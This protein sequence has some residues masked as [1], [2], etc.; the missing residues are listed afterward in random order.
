MDDYFTIEKRVEDNRARMRE[1]YS[2]YKGIDNY[3]PFFL[4]YF[5]VL[6]IYYYDLIS[7]MFMEND[8]SWFTCLIFS[9]TFLIGYVSM[10]I[11]D[12]LKLKKDKIIIITDHYYRNVLDVTSSNVLIKNGHCQKVNSVDELIQGNYLK[13]CF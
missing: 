11:W 9:L 1:L 5:T 3:Y 6:A 13:E 7:F 2:Q 10:L 12:M 4:A 8:Q